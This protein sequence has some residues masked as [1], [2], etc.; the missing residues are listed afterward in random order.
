MP[1]VNYVKIYAASFAAIILINLASE[2][3][4]KTHYLRFS[5]YALVTFSSI[6][7]DIYNITLNLF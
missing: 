7:F 4:L 3:K 5:L 6:N 1:Y 2:E